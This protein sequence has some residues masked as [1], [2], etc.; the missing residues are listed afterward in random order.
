MVIGTLKKYCNSKLLSSYSF[1]EGS[2]LSIVLKL[3]SELFDV[4][5]SIDVTFDQRS[6]VKFILDHRCYSHVQAIL[7]HGN[8]YCPWL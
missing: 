4:F 2:I 6:L 7:D 3:T 8:R 1:P 5:S